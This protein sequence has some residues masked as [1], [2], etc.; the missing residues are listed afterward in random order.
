M[1]EELVR[2]TR[3]RFKVADVWMAPG[4]L[5][6]KLK[7]IAKRT[8]VSS[9]EKVRLA[10]AGLE[11]WIAELQSRSGRTEKA[12]TEEAAAKLLERTAALLE[13]KRKEALFAHEHRL[14]MEKARRA[15]VSH[16][17]AVRREEREAE[18]YREGEA[19]CVAVNMQAA[20][21]AR[22][23]SNYDN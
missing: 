6:H 9:F 3:F 10:E 22:R 14:R 5:R 8:D 11:S 16:I 18:R 1:I 12:A 2:A 17:A 21:T 15:E 23:S 7:G 19:K 4:W 20:R 13:H